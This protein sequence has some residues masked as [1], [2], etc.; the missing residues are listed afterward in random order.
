ME[1]VQNKRFYY[2]IYSFISYNPR[3]IFEIIKAQK[4]RGKLKESHFKRIKSKPIT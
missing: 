2:E 4:L 1:I 3:R